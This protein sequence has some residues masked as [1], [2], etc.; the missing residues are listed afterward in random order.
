ME[1]TPAPETVVPGVP[2]VPQPLA[3]PVGVEDSPPSVVAV[4]PP[5]VF[6]TNDIRTEYTPA[7]QPWSSPQEELQLFI[8]RQ[9][10]K[11]KVHQAKGP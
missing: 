6:A 7:G 1:E 8:Q 4:T 11:S 5:V 3:P 2:A 10:G 9:Q